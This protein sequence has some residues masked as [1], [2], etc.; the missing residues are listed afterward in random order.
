MICPLGVYVLWLNEPL[1]FPPIPLFV[2]P[3][4]LARLRVIMIWVL[5]M[6]LLLLL[7]MVV[8]GFSPVPLVTLPPVLGVGLITIM[9]AV[10]PTT[11]HR[12]FECSAFGAP[13]GAVLKLR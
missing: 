4:I 2:V 1:T 6:L 8:R 7:L 11:I 10:T 3:T 13:P 5:I 12:G 9:V